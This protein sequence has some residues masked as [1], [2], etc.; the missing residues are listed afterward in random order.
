M[1]AINAA[2]EIDL[3]GQVCS[4][5]LGTTFY[6]GIGG[7]V[8]FVRG[9]ARSEQGRPVIALPSTV[10]RDGQTRS[11]IVSM[12]KPGA[13]VVTS[14]GDVHWVVTEFGAADL[15]GRTIRERAL[16]LI[17]IAHPDHREALMREARDRRL[18]YSDQIV[19][20][21]SGAPELEELET[22][23]TASD[24]RKVKLRPIE[25]TDEPL[26]QDLFYR[27]SE[28]TIYMRFFAHV[29]AL[30][31]RQAQT[32]LDVDYVDRL[33]LVATA[34]EKEREVII[35]VGRYAREPGGP[36]ADCAFTV[37]DDW[38]DKGIG[39]TLVNRLIEVARARGVEGF[40]AD[41]LVQNTRMMHVFHQCS[42][43]PV[44]SQVEDGSYHI[45]FRLTAE[46]EGG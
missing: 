26:L 30:P 21:E 39:R 40:E 45:R 20:E 31:H 19:V 25:P 4:D 29:K 44:R 24:G 3:T 7:Q 15:H 37:R 18:V 11:R 43:G 38:Q 36:Y 22:E 42:P 5:S 13:G 41:V 27:C 6:S 35:A 33:A 28:Q 17:H 14:R 1:V 12:L 9:A 23:F 10:E 8:D 34:R 2:L 32:F 46:G 16:A